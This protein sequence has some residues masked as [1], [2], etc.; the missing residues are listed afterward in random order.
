M[1]NHKYEKST[2]T[3]LCKKCWKPKL[4]EYHLEFLDADDIIPAKLGTKNH[5]SRAAEYVLDTPLSDAQERQLKQHENSKEPDCYG[6]T[7]PVCGIRW[8]HNYKCW[9]GKDIKDNMHCPK[10]FGQAVV[11]IHRNDD[12]IQMLNAKVTS[13]KEISELMLQHESFVVL[14]ASK[15]DNFES[16]CAAHINNLREL[17]EKNNAK[18]YATRAALVK[19]R[20][21]NDSKLTPEEIEQYKRNAARQKKE[22]K[23]SEESAAKKAWKDELKDLASLVGKDVAETKLRKMYEAKGLKVPE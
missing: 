9:P 21:E 5:D 15:S 18:I 22:R 19:L 2:N 7:C 3:I 6:H 20:K 10:C 16:W 17:I 8:S 23:V 11:E 12:I 4:H 14:E 1:E 13:A